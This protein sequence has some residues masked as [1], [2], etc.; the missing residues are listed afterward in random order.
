MLRK[1]IELAAILTVAIVTTGLLA[2]CNS[3]PVTEES[4]EESYEP[5]WR[6][7]KRYPI[8]QWLKDG[9]FGIYTHWGIYSVPALGPNGTGYGPAMYE[10]DSEQ[11]KHHVETYGPPSEFGYKDFIPMFKAEKFDADEWA[12]LFE[13]SGAKFA[14]PVVEHHDGFAM[15][16]TKYSEWNAVK[17]GPKRDVVAELEKAI[18]KRDMKFVTTFHHATN[19]TYFPV[20]DESCDCS[21]PQYSGLYGPIHERGEKP[22]KEYLDEWH[23]KIIEVIDKYDPDLVWFDGGL[24]GIRDD[25]IKN[26]LAYFYNKSV[27]RGKEVVASYKTHDFPPG[28]GL[29]DIGGMMPELTHH[30]WMTDTSVDDPAAW[31]YTTNATFRSV[32]TL[33]DNLVD[34]VSKNGFLLLNIGP[35]PDGTFP[36]EAKER[37]LGIGEWLK[38]NGEAIYGT[39]AWI[40]YGEGPAHE[41]LPRGYWVGDYIEFQKKR[42]RVQ[43]TAQDIRFT[44]K[45]NVIYAISLDWP[46]D[47]VTIKYLAG[48]D[49]YVGLD[50]SEI[51]SV[52]M[53]GVDEELEWKMTEDGL[54]IKPPDKKPCEHAFTFKI[55]RKL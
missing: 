50:E 21:D 16:D 30:M 23:G 38:V 28:V 45:D 11:H 32:N 31:S 42:K 27:E 5:T 22:S 29:Q 44:V 14:G 17:M 19:W 55:E 51:K 20:W 40:K 3:D 7:L 26:F 43:L 15:W 9:K 53:L 4:D 41:P 39:T 48:E 2:S 35:K 47:E 49:E 10:S 6:S 52:K 8:P 1:S 13:K 24:T 25:Y 34:R 54:T 33:V 12:E 36:E 18:K 37:L 46:S